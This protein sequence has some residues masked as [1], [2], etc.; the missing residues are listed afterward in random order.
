MKTFHK[1]NFEN[2]VFVVSECIKHKIDKFIFASSCSVY[3]ESNLKCSEDSKL[4]PV[5]LY[6]QM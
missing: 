2:T 1:N 3:G 6:K 4:N 5:S